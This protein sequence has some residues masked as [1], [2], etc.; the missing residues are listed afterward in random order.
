MQ[1]SLDP[2][3][4][5][6]LYRRER[7]A[8][9]ES[10]VAAE[11]WFAIMTDRHFRVPSMRLAELHAVHTPAAYGYLFT[12]KS[13]GWDGKRGASHEVNT[14]FLFGTSD[15]PE[16]RGFV[17]PSAEIRRLSEQIQD[18]WLAF[19]RVGSPHGRAAG[20]GAIHRCAP[21]HHAAGH[22]V[23]RRRPAFLLSCSPPLDRGLRPQA[24]LRLIMILISGPAHERHWSSARKRDPMSLLI[25]WSRSS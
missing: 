11:L 7:A 1:A 4:A 20:M 13:P 18:A 25:A 8:R 17:P 12:W 14:R 5:V 21:E 10:T 2:A 19:A 3:E 23:R 9:G 6:A 24:S 15:S 16:V 22:A